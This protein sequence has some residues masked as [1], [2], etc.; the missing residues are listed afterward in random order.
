MK[1]ETKINLPKWIDKVIW[2]LGANKRKRILTFF[3]LWTIED[4]LFEILSDE[5]RNEIDA[6]ILSK[7][8]I[9]E[10]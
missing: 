8:K 5:I 6:E 3:G 2:K 9:N 7:V 10:N 4:E 1:A